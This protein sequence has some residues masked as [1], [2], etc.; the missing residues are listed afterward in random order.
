MD[1][2]RGSIKATRIGRGT[3]TPAPRRPAPRAAYDVTDPARPRGVVHHTLTKRQVLAALRTSLAP[4][5]DLEAHL[6]PDP[7]LL[8]AATHH[9]EITTRTCPWCAVDGLCHIKYVYGDDLGDKAG[10]ARTDAELR[11]MAHEFGEFDVWL[12]E[13]CV[14][15]GWNHV[16]LTYTLG[17]GRARR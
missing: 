12:V 2:A 5:Y 7:Y 14:S 9:G 8:R 16:H 4:G 13:V 17:D 11:E 6:D 3:L 10:S 15:C 1:R